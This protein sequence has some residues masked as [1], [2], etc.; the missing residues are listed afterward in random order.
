MGRA[1]HGKHLTSNMHNLTGRKFNRLYVVRK[2][3]HRNHQVYWHCKC[4]CGTEREASGYELTKGKVKSCGCLRRENAAK[5]TLVHGENKGGVKSFEYGVWCRIRNKCENPNNDRYQYYGARGITVCEHWKASFANFLE[6]M[7]R[8]PL[9][10][11]IE[12]KNNNGN[13]EPDN[14][15][16]ACPETQANNKRNNRFI[17][18]FGRRLT[19]SQWSRTYGVDC[20]LIL[21]RIKHGWPVEEAISKSPRNY[22]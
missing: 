13:Y 22:S 19:L 5:V 16:W 6:D 10:F 21:Y 14:C 4:D 2:A 8:A 17:E 9:G 3:C 12:R 1:N 15:I 20:S 18:C 11:S 7:G